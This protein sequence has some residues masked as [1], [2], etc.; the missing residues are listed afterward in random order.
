MG[1]FLVAL[2]LSVLLAGVWGCEAGPSLNEFYTDRTVVR[3][4]TIVGVWQQPPDADRQQGK[5][6]STPAKITISPADP[7]GYLVSFS[8]KTV[9][10][11]PPGLQE[12]TFQL[13]LFKVGDSLFADIT[14]SPDLKKAL[15]ETYPGMIIV[16][17]RVMRIDVEKDRLV[18]HA[19]SDDVVR[20]FSLATIGHDEPKGP[21]PLSISFSPRRVMTDPSERLQQSLLRAE[22]AGGFKGESM[23]YVR[24]KPQ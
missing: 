15:E 5:H 22:A 8:E 3:D 9:K 21:K 4:D 16:T 7:G 10:P 12:P 1:R 23:I 18:V 17:H 2:G 6:E 20:H 14:L 19:A 24:V 13:T 11:P